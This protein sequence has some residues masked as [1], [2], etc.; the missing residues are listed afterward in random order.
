MN[1]YDFNQML[2]THK[3]YL[4]NIDCKNIRRQIIRTKN[5][6]KHRETSTEQRIRFDLHMLSLQQ[7]LNEADHV[8]DRHKNHLRNA[9]ALDIA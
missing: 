9:Y 6:I 2:D 4:A 1:D 5:L 8:L 7:Q 3:M